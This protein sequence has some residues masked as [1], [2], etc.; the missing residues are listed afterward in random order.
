VNRGLR[1][2]HGSMR[3][4]TIPGPNIA[5]GA[6]RPPPDGSASGCGHP[7]RLAPVTPLSAGCRTAGP[8]P[9]LAATAPGLPEAWD[10]AERRGQLAARLPK[11]SS[12]QVGS[13][14][15]FDGGRMG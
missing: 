8:T 10:I 9:P 11:I 13:D 1:F 14:I 4:G 6:G 3:F 7:D 5:A 15:P 12:A 2:Q